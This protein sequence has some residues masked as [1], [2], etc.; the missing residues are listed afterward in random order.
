MKN[1]TPALRKELQKITPG[2]LVDSQTTVGHQEEVKGEMTLRQRQIFSLAFRKTT[3][4]DK[5]YPE[6]AIGAKRDVLTQ[7]KDQLE[8]D[9]SLLMLTLR[10]SI[11]RRFDLRDSE[12][13]FRQ[14]F[15]IVTLPPPGVIYDENNPPMNPALFLKAALDSGTRKP[16]EYQPASVIFI[17]SS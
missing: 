11:R 6:L 9:V 2:K 1:L 16:F 7:R 8:I 10:E 14:G 13:G 5:I 12:F 17:K 4:L 3:Q 15:K